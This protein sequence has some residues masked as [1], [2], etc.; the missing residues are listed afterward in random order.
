MKTTAKM[1]DP[2][3]ECPKRATVLVPA[4]TGVGTA[5]QKRVLVMQEGAARPP[6][7]VLFARDMIAYSL[8]MLVFPEAENS[9]P[10]M[11]P[12]A[13]VAQWTPLFPAGSSSEKK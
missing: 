4:H 12:W 5:S 7:G 9:E 11:V 6:G 13:N 1:N 3:P 8:G 10:I 2:I